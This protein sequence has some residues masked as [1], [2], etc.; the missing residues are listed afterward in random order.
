MEI[1]I[2]VIAASIAVYS[3][4]ILGSILPERVLSLSLIHI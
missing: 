2:A 4:K 3:W 1:W